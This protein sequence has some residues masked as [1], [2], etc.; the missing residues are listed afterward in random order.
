MHWPLGQ[1]ANGTYDSTHYLETWRGMMTA[2]A[3]NLTRSIGVSNFNQ[4]MLENIR[5]HQLATPA[6]LQIEW[7]INLQQPEL[8]AYCRQHNISV[9]GYTP[10]G[11]LMDKRRAD[12]PTRIDDPLLTK[13]AA[14]YGK[15]VPQILL[16]YAVEMGVVPI[17]KSITSSRIFENIEIFDFELDESDK[18]TLRDFD[19]GYRTVPQLKWRDHPFYPFEMMPDNS[20]T[21]TTTTTTTTAATTST[22][23]TET[24]KPQV[25]SE[26]DFNDKTARMSFRDIKI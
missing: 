19:R 21:T 16:R 3:R 13:M 24:S 11:A 10:F 18:R 22:V 2:R 23:N 26:V 4:L 9:M 7:N 15:N 12:S 1:F 17:P 25:I 6:V 14:K 8:L 5:L 20:T